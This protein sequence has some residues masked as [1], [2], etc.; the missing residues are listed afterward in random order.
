MKTKRKKEAHEGNVGEVY[1]RLIHM[2]RNGKENEALNALALLPPKIK[3]GV[4][5]LLI[6][7][8]KEDRSRKS[9]SSWEQGRVYSPHVFGTGEDF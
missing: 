6:E 9:C 3:K 2:I 8:Q 7:W 1:N 4:T 5:T